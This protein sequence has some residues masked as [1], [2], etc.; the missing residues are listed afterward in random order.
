MFSEAT[1]A[2]SSAGEHL[3]YKEGRQFKSVSYQM[4]IS[5]THK[6]ERRRG[7]TGLTYLPVTQEIMGSNPIATAIFI[8]R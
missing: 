3:P 8:L 1:G 6:F 4:N 7:V 5:D 2:N